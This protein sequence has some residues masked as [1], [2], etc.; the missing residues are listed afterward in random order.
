MD[1]TTA[2][3]RVMKQIVQQ[4][5]VPITN[6]YVQMVGR[7]ERQNVSRNLNFAMENVTVKMEL[8]KRLLVQRLLVLL[9]VVNIN[10]DHL[11]P[12]VNVIA[13]LD[14]PSQAIIEPALISTS[15]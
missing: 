4:S 6:F 8:M 2:L 14:E 11:L 13:L 10:V 7:I 5:L 3:M 12:E 1:T 9:L 15:A